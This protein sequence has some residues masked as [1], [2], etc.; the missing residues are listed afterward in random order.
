VLR[1]LE[2]FIARSEDPTMIYQSFV[3]P[4]LDSILGDYKAVPPELRDAEVLQ[5]LSTLVDKLG[6]PL[7]PVCVWCCLVNV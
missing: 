6:Q 5:L 7:T 1:L 4:L 2:A 3:P